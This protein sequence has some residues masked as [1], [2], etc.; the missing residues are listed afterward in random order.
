MQ[1]WTF[2]GAVTSTAPVG[3]QQN[4]GRQRPIAWSTRMSLYHRPKAHGWEAMG[5]GG[6]GRGG[7][8]GVGEL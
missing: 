5:M 1:D 8:G 3:R 4:H 7:Q 2:H 6:L